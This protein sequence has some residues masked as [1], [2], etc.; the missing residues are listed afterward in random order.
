[1]NVASLEFLVALLLLS[2]CFY[3]APT[4]RWRQTVLAACSLGF[5]WLQ[6]SNVKSAAALALFL[7]SGYAVAVLLRKWPSRG[8][9]TAYLFALVAAFLVIRKY[10]FVVDYLPRS[11]AMH[12][13]NIVGISYMLFR[14]I[15]FLVDSF[16]GQIDR[17]GI[18]SYAN[19]QL[20]LFTLL[21]GPIQRYQDFKTYWGQLTP[22]AHDRHTLLKT[23]LRLLFG[24]VKITI[25]ATVFLSLYQASASALSPASGL[26]LGRTETIGHFLGVLYFFP[27][28]LYLNFSGYCDI[29]IAGAF[30]LG[31][32]LP[33][34]FDHPYLA[35]N[36]IDFWTRFHRTLGFWIRD[37]L[38]LPL[39][40]SVA[41][42][43]PQRAESYAFLCY[44]AAF[45]VAGVWHGPT[46]N[47]VAYGI[48]QAIGVS[49]AKL[50]ERHLVKRRGRAGLKLYMQ[51]S[52]IRITAIIC[53]LHFEFFALL[54]FPADIHT[55]THMLK[56]V[57]RAII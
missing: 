3:F 26:T 33:E 11:L 30:L 18:W 43:W 46:A 47:F 50:W 41:E 39:Y 51:S 57:Y 1:M 21:S 28:Y 55:A 5:L 24:F 7:F 17:V 53:T 54:F 4:I 45:F 29:V 42:R 19:Y 16:E 44:F 13:L 9:F 32:K 31:M 48:L 23:Y 8:L 2:S 27:I 34:N 12:T 10:D 38:F 25:V 20:N 36:V 22:L 35:R 6:I 40:K 49:A 52:R 15:H 14:Q 56:A 37:Y